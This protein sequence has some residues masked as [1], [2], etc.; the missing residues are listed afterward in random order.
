MAPGN[1]FDGSG[2]ACLLMQASSRSCRWVLVAL[3]VGVVGAS[4]DAAIPATLRT[5]AYH[6]LTQFSPNGVNYNIRAMAMSADGKRIACSRTVSDPLPRNL[7]YGVPFGGGEAQLVDSW[8]S[9]AASAVDISADGSTILAWDIDGVVRVV[10]G[11]GGNPRQVV[12]LNGG[13]FGLRLSGDGSKVYFSVDRSFSTTPDTG[14]HEAGLYVINSDGTGGVRT[15]V[16]L[17]MFAAVL[18]RTPQ[19]IGG[20]DL[21][22]WGWAGGEG[23]GL[24]S[25]ADRLVVI[26]KD[27]TAD[28]IHLFATSPSGSL[29]ELPAGDHALYSWSKIGLSGNGS[30]VF[31]VCGYAPCCSSGDEVTVMD[32]EGTNRRVLYS[33]YST[34]QSAGGLGIREAGLNQDGSK[35]LLGETGWLFNTDGSGRIQLNW[36]APF[37]DYRIVGGEQRFTRPMLDGSGKRVAFLTVVGGNQFQV[38]TAEIDPASPG[39]APV[40]SNASF[41]PAYIVKGG[42]SALFT[43]GVNSTN[44]LLQ[45]GGMQ[46]GPLLDGILD[47]GIWQ[48]TTLHDDGAYGDGAANDRVYSDNAYHYFGVPPLGPRTIRFK[49]EAL[50]ADGMYH[51]SAV[52]LGPLFVVDQ[53]PTGPAPTVTGTS[54][55]GTAS[56]LIITGTGF[57]PVPTNDVVL[58]GNVWV[59]VVSA[60]T[61][62][63]QLVVSLPPGLPESFGIT[64][65]R[66][67]LASEPFTY[68][69]PEPQP[70]L[71][72]KMLAGIEMTGTVGRQ[73]RIE[74][75][76]DFANPDSWLALTTLTLPSSPYF[77]V[78]LTSTNQPQRFYR[79]VRI[80]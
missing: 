9:S 57:D 80:P 54:Q 60:N 16:T 19:Q 33:I 5:L 38:G 62:G 22:L 10:G 63:T 79:A 14:P 59:Q 71:L 37:A 65:S 75:Q 55:G 41:T 25:G 24:A 12:K 39:L 18:G 15:I 76:A 26:M 66:A 49:A 28:A 17:S 40:L 43:A 78:D 30:K 35:L 44:G 70:T 20:S 7:I 31:S 51:A 45:N 11:T 67:G 64:V 50:G 8:Q 23:F 21:Q 53:A 69:T 34:N 72:L 48:G 27:V 68:G 74:Y 4:A 56:Q 46:C 29:R 58:C 61:P 47:P 36:T 52:D 2:P 3:S 1:L 6:Q 42:P 73:Y 77:W 13:F 32:W